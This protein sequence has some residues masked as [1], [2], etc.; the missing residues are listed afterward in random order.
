MIL[1]LACLTCA[2]LTAAACALTYAHRATANHARDRA[3]DRATIDM[4]CQRIQAPETA[5]AEHVAN[6]TDAPMP[7]PPPLDD[8]RGYW[9]QIEID[10]GG[11]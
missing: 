11:D 4:L 2:A 7:Q 5:V 1:A 8:D 6:L 3:G 9:K 10:R